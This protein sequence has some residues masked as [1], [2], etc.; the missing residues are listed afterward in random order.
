MVLLILT[1]SISHPSSKKFFFSADRDYYEV[2][3]T[4]ENKWASFEWYICSVNPT[5]KAE[6]KLWKNGRKLVSTDSKDRLSAAN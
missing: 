1:N 2:V 3:Q 6:G 4:S 5:P